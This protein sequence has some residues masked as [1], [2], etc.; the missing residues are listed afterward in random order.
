[1]SDAAAAGAWSYD[2][3]GRLLTDRRTTNGITKNTTY[4]YAPY[5]D[6]SIN[7]VT[8]HSGRIITYTPQS[9][10]TNTAGRLLS[11]VD[12]TGPINYATAAAYTP[13]GALVSLTNGA[14][15]TSIL[16]YN[17]RLQESGFYISCPNLA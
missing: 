10:G 2:V 13:S 11:A 3:R 8:Y 15:L 1:M 6:G 9:S 7:T 14:S 12:S 4:A 17:S 16:F 5:L